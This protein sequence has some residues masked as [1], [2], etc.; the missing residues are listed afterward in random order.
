M[1]QIPKIIQELRE[2]I[3]AAARRRL[4]TEGYAALSLR[5][6]ARDCSIAVGTIYNYFPDK[7]TLIASVMLVDWLT[8]LEK[9]DRGCTGARTT[10]EGY[11]AIYAAIREFA[12]IYRE[13]W[14]QFAQTG[15][16]SGELNSR[17]LMLRG[18]LVARISPL[19]ERTGQAGCAD[20]APILAE[21][22]LATAVQPD[23]A[24]EQV[25]AFL[26]RLVP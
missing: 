12:Q 11:L 24:P 19:L 17:H 21:T 9:M 2:R 5:G 4:L 26:Q 7:N 15:G 16:S 23:I 6:I 13:V 25:A 14:T 10:A 8:A 1:L 3:L 18:Q 20:I 22:A